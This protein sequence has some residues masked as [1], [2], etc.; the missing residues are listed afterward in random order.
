L[1]IAHIIIFIITI[2]KMLGKQV[3]EVNLMRLTTTLNE[4]NKFGSSD[5]GL[6]RLAYTKEERK[7]VEYFTDLC[8]KEGLQVRI[9]SCGNLI[10]RREGRNP[11]LPAVACGSHLD[12][13]IQGGK[14]DGAI[15]VVA[16]LEVVRS[17]NDK[18]IVTEHPIEIICFACEESSRFG[19]ST[20]GSKVMVGDLKKESV[21]ELKD[22]NGISIREAF[23]DCSLDLE[24]WMNCARQKGELKT[25]LELHIEQG[26]VLEAENKQIGVVYSIAAPTRLLVHVQ[27]KGS[28]TGT[29]P[30]NLR[31]DALL[32]AAEIALDLEFAAQSESM[33]GTV[34]TVGVC[35][36][37]PGAINVIPDSAQLKIDIRGTSA[38]SKSVV[39]QKLMDSFERLKQKRGLEITWSLLSDERPIQLDAEVIHSLST[40]CDK[41]GISYIQMASGAGHDAM[42]MAKICPTGMIF[43]PSR[44]GLSHHPDEYTSMEQFGVGAALLEE[45]MMKWAGVFI[46]ET[47]NIQFPD[48]RVS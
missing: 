33:N 12:T 25:F 41:L 9:D 44:D 29:T 37:K 43:V 3:N 14:Y 11:D 46:T 20:I 24:D 28:H 31:K 2:Y 5:K 39:L 15:G 1:Q 32:G 40:T 4:I 36:V 16:A 26:P 42:N 27:G 17:L 22:K 30:M 45:E 35:E 23:I 47:A 21:A 7:A 19:V 10:A 8:I 18:G 13:V 48:G 38:E 6:M 34:A